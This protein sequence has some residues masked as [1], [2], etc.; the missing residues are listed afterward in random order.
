MTRPNFIYIGTSKAGSTWIFNL[1]S[2]HPDVFMVPNKG[3][4]FF[5]THYKRGLDWYLGHFTASSN[6]RVRCEISHSYLFS[7]D[8][9]HRI[10][11]LNPETKLMVCVREPVE[12]AFSEYLDFVKNGRFQGSFEEALVQFP[13]LKDHGRY[14][15]HLRPY[16]DLFGPEQIFV[17]V[18][19]DIKTASENFANRMFSFLE[20]EQIV[21][22]AHLR[23][24][25]NAG[26]IP[27]FGLLTKGA[28][29]GSKT[30]KR[31][32]MRKMVGFAKRS[33][34]I[35]N[36]LYR[37]FTEKD[38]PTIREETRLMLKNEYKDEVLQLDELVGTNLQSRWDY[39]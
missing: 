24:K 31:L 26:G 6:F 33:T 35:K 19:D 30:L 17:G 20:I 22:Q 9:C 4:Y 36:F 2:H 8:A 5:D 34:A 10:A 25:V 21:N 37:P 16:Y 12:R 7:Q 39:M 13:S 18:F 28:K 27:R 3:L 29:W 38:R 14:Y 11:D 15:T 32:G 1:L 23:K